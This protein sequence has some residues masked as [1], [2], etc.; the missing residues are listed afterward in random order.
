MSVIG[1]VNRA[2]M[3]PQNITPK[4]MKAL[5]DLAT[6]DDDLVLPA[7]K[8]K[9]TV[10]MDKQDTAYTVQVAIISSKC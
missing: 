3:P 10:V 7:D 1:A 8:G 6:D 4:E 9:A 5:R 2:K